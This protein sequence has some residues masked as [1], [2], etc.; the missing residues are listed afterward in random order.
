MDRLLKYVD[1][2][3]NKE[4]DKII[5]L[6]DYDVGFDLFCGNSEWGRKV[7]GVLLDK[8]KLWFLRVKV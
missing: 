7:K 6:E 8:F 5:G 4:D 1:E 3:S 2:D